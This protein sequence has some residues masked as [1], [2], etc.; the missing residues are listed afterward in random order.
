MLL[1]DTAIGN[2]TVRWECALLRGSTQPIT[3]LHRNNLIRE[4]FYPWERFTTEPSETL[5]GCQCAKEL[6]QEYY[7]KR[8]LSS[9]LAWGAGFLSVDSELFILC[10][11]RQGLSSPFSVCETTWRGQTP[12]YISTPSGAF[13]L[14]MASGHHDAQLFLGGIW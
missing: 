3:N 8:K 10:I 14:Y 2:P 12:H 9:G 7:K 4:C 13:F 1:A 11:K 5:F 6:E